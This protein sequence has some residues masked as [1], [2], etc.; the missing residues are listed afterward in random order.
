MEKLLRPFTAIVW[1]LL[2]I[3]LLFSSFLALVFLKFPKI[4]NFVFGRGIKHPLT[5]IISIHL[6]VPQ[7]RLPMRNFSR[8]IL[9]NF[10][11][12]CL[13]IRSSYQGAV[14]N[15]LMSNEKK[16]PVA[17]ISEIMEKR[18][19]FYIYESLSSR[20][21]SLLHAYKK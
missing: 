19:T 13:V 10:L 9:L 14:F 20:V 8:F 18:Y 4:F 21:Q 7:P 5:N 11:T 3:I 6:G 1:T 16:P 12:Y 2:L 15:I 17:S